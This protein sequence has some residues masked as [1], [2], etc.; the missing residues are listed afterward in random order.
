MECRLLQGGRPYTKLSEWQPKGFALLQLLLAQPLC[1]T[2]CLGPQACC[3]SPVGVHVLQQLL[4]ALHAVHTLQRHVLAQPGARILQARGSDG[5]N[6]AQ[7]SQLILVVGVSRL[8]VVV[9]R[10]LRLHL[11]PM[12][13]TMAA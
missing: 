13:G 6:V 7:P 1:S 8:A 2:Q 4:E 9:Q 5:A 12:A 3:C 10:T 11:Q